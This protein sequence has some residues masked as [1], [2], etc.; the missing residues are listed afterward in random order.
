M[1]GS[2]KAVICDLDDT[3]FDCTGQLVEASRRRAARALVEAGLPVSQ[4]EALALQRE[5]AEEH[6]PYF[7]V[8]N[9]IARRYGLGDDAVDAAYHAYNSEEVEDIKPF[10][11]V[12]PTLRM[13][14]CQGILCFLLTAGIYGRQLRK[15]R[16]LGLEDEFDE[17]MINDYERGVVLTDCMRYFL[18]R[19]GLREQEVMVVGDRPQAEI[20]AGN[21]LGAATAQVMHGKFS[22][23]PPR[24]RLEVADYTIRRISQ[25]P[26]I[27]RLAELGKS[28]GALRIVA[29]GGG[30]GL[31]IVLEG[32]KTY[33]TNPTAIV[34]VTDCGRSSGR[35]REELGMP[36]PGD[37][38]NC[39]I[40]LSASGAQEQTVNTLFQYRFREGSFEGMSLGNLI[41]A[42]MSDMTG[43]FQS[44]VK[45]ISRLLNIKGKVLPS[46]VTDC[47]VCAEF[48][49]G[50]VAEGE[51][52]VR[53][54]GTPRIRR[55]FLKPED[56][57]APEEALREIKSAD[58]IA[59]GPGSLF[60]SVITN[61]LVPDI[62]RAISESGARKYY[63]CNIVTQPGQTDGFTAFDH[64]RAVQR[65]LGEGVL[66][67]VV[68][69]SALPDRKIL[70]NYRQEGAELVC[71]DP[72][73]HSLGVNVVEADLLEDMDEQRVLWEKQDLLRHHPDKLGDVLC[74]LYAGI[75]ITD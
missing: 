40:A 20:R 44:G 67:S 2:F 73:L 60:T 61:L 21:E 42:A 38:R 5:L 26:T 9:E 55:L 14:R 74:R 36:P 37:A 7:L 49:D 71:A 24:D 16:K 70:E 23:V 72:E 54:T 62:R 31:P 56:A 66:D 10:P 19:Y 6:G 12:V 28:P 41:I 65:Y 30:T 68:I 1:S 33:C 48:E 64:V 4:E 17:V 53:Q 29:I 59:I 8:F 47:H 57:R 52:N 75:E 32:C 22:A 11:D 45:A 13:L 15:L 35:L 34:A 27:L 50:S 39:L 46:A 43:S 51:V 69:N 25:V 58:I 18:D 3:L 63:V